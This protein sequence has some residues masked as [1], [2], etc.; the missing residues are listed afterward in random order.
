[1]YLF[2]VVN[3]TVSIA[4][5]GLYWMNCSTVPTATVYMISDATSVMWDPSLS[6]TP[7]TS[8]VLPHNKPSL[9]AGEYFTLHNH[10]TSCRCPGRRWLEYWG[11]FPNANQIGKLQAV[12]LPKHLTCSKGKS[13]GLWINMRPQQNISGEHTCVNALNKP[14][15]D[16]IR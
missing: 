16:C 3:H 13:K 7:G 14:Y 11:F 15:H 9:P 8:L 6:H 5:Y 2:T 10:V 12:A 4:I 1:M